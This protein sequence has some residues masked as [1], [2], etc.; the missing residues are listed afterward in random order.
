VLIKRKGKDYIMSPNQNAPP[1]KKASDAERKRPEKTTS[2]KGRALSKEK[3]DESTPPNDGEKEKV[4]KAKVGPKLEKKSN[5]ESE[6]SM[7]VGEEQPTKKKKKKGVIRDEDEEEEDEFDE[8]E[9]LFDDIEVDSNESLHSPSE[10]A[11]GK[12]SMYLASDYFVNLL[13]EDIESLE[14]YLKMRGT[15]PLSNRVKR[16]INYLA[17]MQNE[18]NEEKAKVFTPDRA[19]R[20][21][22]LT[23]NMTQ[24]I[25]KTRRIFPEIEEFYRA[26][27]WDSRRN[28]KLCEVPYGE[29]KGDDDPIVHTMKDYLAGDLKTRYPPD[30]ANQ[31]LSQ[32]FTGPQ[33]ERASLNDYPLTC[34]VRT[35]VNYLAYLGAERLK[36]GRS[37]VEPEKR[38]EKE[39]TIQAISRDMAKL[40][41]KIRPV[42]PQIDTVYLPKYWSH[43]D[44]YNRG[45]KR[46]IDGAEVG[47]ESKRKKG[48][49]PEITWDN[50]NRGKVRGEQLFGRRRVVATLK[51]EKKQK[52]HFQ[53][54]KRWSIFS[55]E[56]TTMR[57]L[58]ERFDVITIARNPSAS[59]ISRA[60]TSGKEAKAYK[61]SFPLSQGMISISV[62]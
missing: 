46:K 4:S 62:Y 52:I 25:T 1:A 10:Y 33:V 11:S 41:S 26:D 61:M 34:E 45:S 58:D 9:M 50:S 20:I 55:D 31:L 12:R 60:Q 3:Y 44:G 37:T 51:G 6:Q 39:K 13:A 36:L 23:C 43:I 17:F 35:I 18:L 40:I 29:E 16:Y 27:E 54:N 2:D 30:F 48:E 42:Y 24:L 15:Y 5:S 7:E 53:L 22:E 14:R 57:G 21:R 59:A 19:L 49:E 8:S 47:L 56:A 32:E 28:E 38:E